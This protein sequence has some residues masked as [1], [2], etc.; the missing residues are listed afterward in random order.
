VFG[1]DEQRDEELAQSHGGKQVDFVHERPL[2]RRE[3]GHGTGLSDSKR[4]RIPS[5]YYGTH[6]F[7]ENVIGA[8]DIIRG[9]RA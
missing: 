7:R 2:G 8:V 6:R 3:T 1:L 5:E 4:E 9:L